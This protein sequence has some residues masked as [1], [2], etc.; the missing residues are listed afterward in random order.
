MPPFASREEWMIVAGVPES[1]V[2][3]AADVP[4]VAHQ[5]LRLRGEVVLFHKQGCC[6]R[7]PIFSIRI[8]DRSHELDKSGQ[9]HVEE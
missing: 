7:D 6:E 9:P 3:P 1:G 4:H 8:H 5:S 2:V